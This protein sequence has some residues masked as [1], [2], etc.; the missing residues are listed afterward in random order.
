MAMALTPSVMTPLGTAAPDF[1]LP[2]PRRGRVVRLSDFAGKKA[3]LVMFLCNHC[4]Y[5]KHV[6]SELVRLGKDF[7]KTE[8]GLVAISANDPT[9]YPD[10]APEKLALEAARLDYRFPLLFDQTQDVARAYGAAC[11]P[12]FF[13]YDGGRR[14]VY[15]GQLYESRPGNGIPPSGSDLRSAI[16]QVLAGQSVNPGQKPSLGCNI[17]WR[18]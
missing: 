14:L 16:G 2:D 17:K 4:P 9:G 1:A 15:R 11:T 7:E 5:V 10:D 6:Q 18:A 3:L 8:A 13:L 12:D